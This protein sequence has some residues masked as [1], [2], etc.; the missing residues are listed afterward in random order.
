M[1][2]S[3]QNQLVLLYSRGNSEFLVNYKIFF[4]GEI[5]ILLLSNQNVKVNFIWKFFGYFLR[6][7]M[8]S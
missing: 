4:E 2:W 1:Q 7:W 5:S 6:K 8:D 3:I